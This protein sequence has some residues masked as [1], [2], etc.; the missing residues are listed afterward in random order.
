[1]IWS[2]R[3]CYWEQGTFTTDISHDTLSEFGCT[4][5]LLVE[6]CSQV[7]RYCSSWLFSFRSH[8]D[9]TENTL[10]SIT[11]YLLFQELL[12]RR[13]EIHVYRQGQLPVEL[14]LTIDQIDGLNAG[15]LVAWIW[16]IIT[17]L[18]DEFYLA[19]EFDSE[20]KLADF[21]FEEKFQA[22]Y[23]IHI[24]IMKGG[25]DETLIANLKYLLD[26]GGS[27]HDGSHLEVGI[28]TKKEEI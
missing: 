21:G 19:G 15:Y 13:V 12:A 28:Q 16:Q 14:Y 25:R 4:F 23:V 8:Q 27:R 5:L 9:Q 7:N 10:N 26:I 17:P 20:W 24:K 3:G 1:M 18:P 22:S 2:V 6:S 11:V